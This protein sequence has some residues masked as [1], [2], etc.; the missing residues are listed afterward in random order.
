MTRCDQAGDLEL[1]HRQII[2]RIRKDV[3]IVAATHQPLSWMRHNHDEADVASFSGRS[4]GAFCGLGNPDSFLQTLQKLGIEIRQW[5]T[6]PDHHNYSRADV[7]DL[8]TWAETLPKDALVLT[9][10]KDAVK[11][12]LGELAGRE[13]WALRIGLQL[14]ESND[15]DEFHRRLDRVLSR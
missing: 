7:N 13:L 5:R 10:Q 11:L 3:P 2:K 4:A 6:F 1:L 8:R 14:E 15:S 9:T 12:R